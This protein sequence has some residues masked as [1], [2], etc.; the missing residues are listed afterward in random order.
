MYLL[1]EETLELCEFI[2]SCWFVEVVGTF[3]V[4][5]MCDVVLVVIRGDWDVVLCGC[6]ISGSV[7]NELPWVGE[8]VMVACD[9]RKGVE[10]GFCHP[11]W[12]HC[13]VCNGR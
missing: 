10:I 6:L 3:D 9:V 4:V 2:S 7:T 8:E 11:R 13:M 12:I 1:A 5:W